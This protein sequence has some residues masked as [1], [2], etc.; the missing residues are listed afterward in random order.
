MKQLHLKSCQ[1]LTDSCGHL[2]NK[3]VAAIAAKNGRS[4]AQTLLRWGLQH[5]TSVIPKSTNPRHM[6]VSCCMRNLHL[7]LHISTQPRCIPSP[8]PWDPAFPPA[9]FPSGLRPDTR[10]Q[11]YWLAEADAALPLY[12]C[13]SATASC[14]WQLTAYQH[15]R[16]MCMD[17]CLV[18]VELCAV[19]LDLTW[20]SCIGT[21]AVKHV[22]C[23]ALPAPQGNLSA[24]CAI[25][26]LLQALIMH[27][28]KS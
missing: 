14:N 17:T 26:L 27:A 20:E 28:V 6:Q 5:G 15:P 12:L 7:A 13:Y 18:G 24:K 1:T 4:V 22:S 19:F 3:D 21:P 25:Y 23:I 10:Y 11:P 2:Q 16:V 8:P 9:C